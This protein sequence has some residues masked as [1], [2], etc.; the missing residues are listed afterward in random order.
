MSSIPRQTST[1]TLSLSFDGY[2]VRMAGTPER[3]E[4]IA[5]DVCRVL[6][7]TTH[8]AGQGVPDGEKGHCTVVTL[9]GPQD[10]VTVTE[11]GIYRLMARSRKPAAQ[12]FQAWVFGE[13]LPSYRQHGQYPP[14]GAIRPATREQQIASALLLA[15]EVISEKDARLAIAEPKAAV[16]DACMSSEDLL[17]VA[18]V[19][20]ILARPGRPL[21]EVRLFRFLRAQRILQYDNRPYQEHVEAGRFIVRETPI[22]IGNGRTR[23]HVQPLVTQRG[24]DYIRRRLDAADGQRSLLPAR[25]PADPKRILPLDPQAVARGDGH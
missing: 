16:Y 8:N 11:A 20:N 2:R 21:G 24:V 6:G 18:Q 4:W 5:K 19:A 25:A 23:I 1:L 9:G 17:T 22:D 14:P 13:V 7:L 3:P 10:F 12:R 15:Q